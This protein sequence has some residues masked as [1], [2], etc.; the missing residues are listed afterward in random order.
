[1]SRVSATGDIGLV[2][3]N[4]LSARESVR[5][6]ASTSRHVRLRVRI[7]REDYALELGIFVSSEYIYIYIYI[8]IYIYT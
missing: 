5:V 4:R 3:A 8:H 6:L 2:A 7:R 1:M